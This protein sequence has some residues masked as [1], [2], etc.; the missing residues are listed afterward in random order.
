MGEIKNPTEGVDAV[1]IFD[2]NGNLQMVVPEEFEIAKGEDVKW[3]ITP[4]NQVKVK[5]DTRSPL[6]WDERE[7]TKEVVGVVKPN[8]KAGS[9][10][11]TVS[12]D[13]GN[14]IDPR[15]R[16]GKH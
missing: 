10:K 13:N 14:F 1:I 5:F 4:Q 12:D 2:K 11:Y 9:Y 16:V 8:A 15:I 7:E 3:L 6:N